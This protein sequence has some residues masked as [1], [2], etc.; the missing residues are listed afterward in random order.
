MGDLP[1]A[2]S[3]ANLALV[4]GSALPVNVF[5]INAGDPDDLLNCPPNNEQYYLDNSGSPWM[6]FD[7]MTTLL[8]ASAQVTPGLQYHMRLE[9]G[10][11][12]D[13]LWDSALFFQVNSFRSVAANTAVSDIPDNGTSWIRCS[14]DHAVQLNG[15]KN[16]CVLRLSDMDGREAA[17][18]CRS[19]P[20]QHPASGT[21]QRH[22]FGRT[23][24]KRRQCLRTHLHSLISARRSPPHRGTCSCRRRTRSHTGPRSA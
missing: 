4:P 21:G 14:S 18:A 15:I 20:A 3:A 24:G 5:N 16:P 10:D 7:G 8:T 13:F 9:L 19:G 2:D 12:D 6:V 23:H 11:A 1:Y 22:L 17:A